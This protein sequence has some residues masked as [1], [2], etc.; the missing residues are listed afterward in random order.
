MFIANSC[1]I[2]A[3]L[4]RYTL[5]RIYGLPSNYSINEA[6]TVIQQTQ[7]IHYVVGG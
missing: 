1:D 7:I 3:T 2:S 6:T 4:Q 5:E